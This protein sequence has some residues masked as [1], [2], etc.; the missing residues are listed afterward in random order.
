M[1]RYEATVWSVGEAAENFILLSRGA[2]G[3]GGGR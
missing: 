2:G 1:K 3:S